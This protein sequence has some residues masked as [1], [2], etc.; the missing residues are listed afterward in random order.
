MFAVK[1][2]IYGVATDID[3]TKILYTLDQLSSAEIAV[4]SE[5][6]DITDKNGSI[7]RTIY[8][9]KTATVTA[10]S[11]LISPVLLNAGSGSDSVTGTL[12]M[13]KIVVTPAGQDLDVSDAIDPTQILVMGIYSNGA[14]GATLEYSATTADATHF[15]VDSGKL[16]TPTEAVGE[17]PQYIVKYQRTAEGLKLMNKADEFPK[18]VSLTFYVAVLDP[19][20]DT[21]RA[22]YVYVPNFTPDPS[23]TISLSSD[24]QEM[25]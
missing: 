14:N 3:N 15:T 6:T 16:K 20:K 5:S 22:A 10:T 7:I 13:P 21:F 11:A 2:V 4:E 23:V 18:T 24:S 25:D 1:E 9:S 8:N 17:A 19:C 12:E